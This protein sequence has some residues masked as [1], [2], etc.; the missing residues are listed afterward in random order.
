M[1]YILRTDRPKN[2]FEEWNEAFHEYS[3]YLNKIKNKITQSVFEFA[4]SAWHYNFEDHRTLH[5]SWLQYVTINEHINRTTK[6]NI[7][8]LGAFQDLFI[9]IEYQNVKKFKISRD[10]LN[11]SK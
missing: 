2:S 5:D 7:R 11:N 10:Y 3:K 9:D 8:L 6:V 1:V 4:T